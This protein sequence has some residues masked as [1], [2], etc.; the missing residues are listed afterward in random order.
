MIGLQEITSTKGK[1][2]FNDDR[3]ISHQINLPCLKP[4]SIIHYFTSTY[5][6]K[7]L[8]STS[9]PPIITKKK[10]EMKLDCHSVTQVNHR[11]KTSLICYKLLYAYNKQ[12]QSKSSI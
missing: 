4:V 3:I 11:S 8:Y 1:F 12:N 5:R 6:N 7:Q 10:S 2:Y 9:L